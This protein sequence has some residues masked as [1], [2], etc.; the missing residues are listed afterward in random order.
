MKTEYLLFNVLIATLSTVSVFIFRKYGARWPNIKATFFAFCV[1]CLPYLIWDHFVTNIWWSFNDRYT[2]GMKI[3]AL[4]IEEV[5]FFCS[6]PWSCLIIWENLKTKM[7]GSLALP[8]ETFLLLSSL[9]F[10]IFSFNKTWY[11]TA[12]VSFVVALVCY[13][14]WFSD[15]WFNKKNSLLFLCG[16]SIL[17]LIFNGYLTARPI[18][19]YSQ[20]FMTNIRIWTIPIEDFF[21]GLALLSGIVIVYERSLHKDHLL[22]SNS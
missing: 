13:M 4:P 2:L 22:D 5:L 17:I 6:V 19:L 14:S 16:V 18:V 10:G 8:I 1:M 3:G 9:V 11:Y 12:I 20:E 15:H 21:Y 7:E